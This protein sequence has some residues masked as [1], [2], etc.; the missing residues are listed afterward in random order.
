[1]ILSAG[2]EKPSKSLEIEASTSRRPVDSGE[3]GE[4]TGVRLVK[5]L[6]LNILESS[7]NTSCTWSELGS[8]NRGE[9]PGDTSPA[10]SKPTGG[11]LGVSK[12]VGV[13]G[14]WPDS[15]ARAFSL[16]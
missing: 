2:P 5:L 4:T 15:G 16:T 13:C 11:E 9:D 3:A 12:R 6:G 1:M 7:L 14:W 8:E 10:P